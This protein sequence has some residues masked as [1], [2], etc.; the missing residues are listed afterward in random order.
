MHPKHTHILRMICRQRTQS[1]YGP[2]CGESGFL[3]ELFEFLLC[4]SENNTLTKYNQRSFRF[5]DHFSSCPDIFF[6]NNRF[7]SVTS[8]MVTFCVSG[9]IKLLQ[10]SILRNVNQYR[11]WSSASGNIKGFCHNCRNLIGIS[12]LIIPFGNR[13]GDVD[14]ICFLESISSKEMCKD[15]SGYADQGC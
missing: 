14:D 3:Y 9:I 11:T 6:S 2:C 5:I 15:L 12:Y 8:D 1:K 4:F 7:G 10:L 13:C